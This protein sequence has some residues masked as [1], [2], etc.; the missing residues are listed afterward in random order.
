VKNYGY[1]IVKSYGLI[2]LMVL[3]DVLEKNH[4]Y[5][6]MVEQLLGREKYI[7]ALRFAIRKSLSESARLTIAHTQKKIVG[8]CV[9]SGDYVFYHAYTGGYYSVGA[10]KFVEKYVVEKDVVITKTCKGNTNF[11]IN[12]NGSSCYYNTNTKRIIDEKQKSMKHNEVGRLFLGS[13]VREC[14]LPSNVLEFSD[15]EEFIAWLLSE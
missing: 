10:K 14:K 8:Y 5:L 9:E 12:A 4:K 3:D 7:E 2:S 11:L 13:E 15:E 1:V 6:G